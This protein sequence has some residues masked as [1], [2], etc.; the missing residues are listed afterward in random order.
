MNKRIVS[1]FLILCFI[2]SVFTFASC[3]RKVDAT[4]TTAQNEA[5][6]PEASETDATERKM[7]EV[8]TDKWEA[9][10]PKITMITEKDRTLKI[11]CSERQTAV[12]GSKN[13]IYLKG[14]DSVEDGVTPLI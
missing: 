1:L 3:G 7:T 10:A 8:P 11:E 5:T 12:K 2:L 14:P 6:E 4:D 9:I 13:D